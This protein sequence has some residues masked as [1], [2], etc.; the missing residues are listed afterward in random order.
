MTLRFRIAFFAALLAPA[1]SQAAKLTALDR[2]VDTPDPNY[3]YELVKTIPSQ[4]YTTYILDMTSQQWRTAAEVDHPI[5]RHWLIIVRP[6]KLASSTGLLFIDG[7]SN[8]RPAPTR[9]ATAIVAIALSSHSVAADLRDVPNEPLVFAG[10]GKQ[11][12]EDAII[13]YTWDKYLRGGDDQWPLRLP[14]TKAAVRAMDTVTAFSKSREGGGVRVDRFVVAGASKRGWT[15]WTTAAVDK[16]VV[17][18]APIV[19]DLLNIEPSF[20]HHWRAYGFW[21]P[22]IKDYQDLHIMD[23]TRTKRYDAL[24]RMV[25]PYSYRGRLTMPKYIIN[26][27]GD[28]FFLPDSSRF[29]WNAL[30]GEK[31]LRYV[32][33]TGHSLAGTD[34]ADS[35]IAYYD[36]IVSGAPLPKVSWKFERD[37]A[38]RMVTGTKPSDVELWQATDAKARDFRVD[39][40]GKAYV[41]KPLAPV[42]EGVY[43]ARVSPPARGWTA[44][45]VE[46]T[47]PMGDH[48]MKITS[49]VRVTPDTLPYPPPPH[50]MA[51]K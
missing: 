27:A 32:P 2:Y 28:Q 31:Y 3:K 39:T 23:W 30:K 25:E 1:A 35:L 50:P 51:G 7:G 15:T 22:A 43:V 47:Y 48:K 11:R 29:Y 8:T 9:A 12:S 24:M 14:M 20:E 49:G 21:A 6:T 10:D 37:G 44:Y 17:A 16:R 33:N 42:K 18:C 46:M 26:A 4:A 5:W 36:A 34:V 38:I 13:A 41:S 19:I 40:L 45:F